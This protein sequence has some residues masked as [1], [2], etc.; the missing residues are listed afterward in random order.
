MAGG[1]EVVDPPKELPSGQE[2]IRQ[3]PEW[4]RQAEE[5]TFIV[6]I[7]SHT[8]QAHDHLS[9]VCANISAL[10]KVTDKATLLSVI[11]GAVR[12][13]VQLNI[14][15]GF[16]NPIEEKK[17]KTTEEEKRE[18]VQR[19]VLP[20]PNAP[21]LAHEPRNGQT[22]ILMAAVWLKMSKKYFNEGT[23][24]EA[25]ECFDVRVK[26]LSRVLTGKKY[27]RG[28]QAHKCKATEEP[29]VRRKKSDG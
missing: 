22:H 24:K 6:D 4:A 25:C 10:A 8:A 15:E 16:L 26:Q 20:I 28:T 3:L 17:S 13:L 14:P 7:F 18:K 12:L 19:I 29:L 21:C 27:L 5:T 2:F 23:A 9:E 11:N 1:I